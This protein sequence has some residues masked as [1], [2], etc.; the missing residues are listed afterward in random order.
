MTKLPPLKPA[1]LLRPKDASAVS[2]AVAARDQ[3]FDAAVDLQ[4]AQRDLV[5][6]VD[7]L[8]AGGYSLRRPAAEADVNPE[9]PAALLKTVIADVMVGFETLARLLPSRSVIV[10]ER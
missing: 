7:L 8:A 9:A 3:I 5:G 2:Q 4:L 1:Q 6:R 10:R